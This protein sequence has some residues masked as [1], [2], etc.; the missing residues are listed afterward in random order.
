MTPFLEPIAKP[1]SIRLRVLATVL[2]RVF[3]KVPSWLSVF[4]ARMPFAFTTWMGKANSLNKKLSIGTDTMA[5]VRARVDDINICTQCQDAGRWYITKKQPHLLPKLDALSDYQTSELF[6]NKER[7]ALAFASELATSRSVSP[8]SFAQLSQYYSER[9]ICE[10]VW[11]VSSNFLMNINNLGLGIG[12]DGLC[13]L[14]RTKVEATSA[15][16]L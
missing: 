15:A 14:G 3:G 9:E 10:L 5:L 11:V 13:E 6:S 8:D 16:R 4:C 12:S 7:A 1:K 2:R